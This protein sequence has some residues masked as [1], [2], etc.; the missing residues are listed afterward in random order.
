MQVLRSMYNDHCDL[1]CLHFNRGTSDYSLWHLSELSKTDIWTHVTWTM[2]RFVVN[3][4]QRNSSEHDQPI[5]YI[6]QSRCDSFT[7]ISPFDIVNLL[8]WSHRCTKFHPRQAVNRL[9]SI[10]Q[11]KNTYFEIYRS[12]VRSRP[13]CYYTGSLTCAATQGCVVFC[14]D[15]LHRDITASPARLTAVASLRRSYKTW[16]FNPLSK[17]QLSIKSKRRRG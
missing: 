12:I 16:N 4:I 15:L 8:A 1:S 7:I 10:V 2:S 3:V 6:R 9:I 11:F 5:L 14:T 17:L 13:R